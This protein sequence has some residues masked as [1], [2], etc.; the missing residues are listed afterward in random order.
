VSSCVSITD[1]SV[2][3]FTVLEVVEGLV[4]QRE[5]VDDLKRQVE[6]SEAHVEFLLGSSDV[7]NRVNIGFCPPPHLLEG[8]SHPG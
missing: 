4:E 5:V 2:E 6:A 3:C 1:W 7:L 8:Q